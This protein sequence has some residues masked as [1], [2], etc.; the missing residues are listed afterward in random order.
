[1]TATLN[2]RRR[3]LSLGLVIL[4]LTAAAMLVGRWYV[5][6][7]QW[8]ESTDNAYIA[9]NLVP[10]STRLAGTVI[11]IGAEEN[12]YIDAGQVILRLENSDERNQVEILEQE[13]ALATRAVAAL[14]EQDRRRATEVDQREVTLQLANEEHQRRLKLAEVSMVSVEEL[15]A[16]RTRSEETRISRDIARSALTRSRLLSGHMPIE[17]HPSVKL[18]AAKLRAAH[19]DLGKT[20][21]V[22]PVSGLLAVRSVQLGQHVSPGEKL[23]SLVQLESVWVE[24]NFKET[25]LTHLYQNQAVTLTSDLYGDELVFTGV[26]SGIGSG[27]GALFSLLPPQNATGNWIKIVQRVPVRIE[28][29][30]EQLQKYPLPLGASLSVVV[31]TSER[32]GAKLNLNSRQQTIFAMPQLAGSDEDVDKAISRIISENIGAPKTKFNQR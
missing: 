10:L 1:M 29:P 18:A 4:V 30:A 32:T 14:R 7:G 12:Q 15:D 20:E 2:N 17:Q 27:T 13:L 19:L 16:A 8:R 28:L 31:N 26:V 23:M 22:A 25:Q 9:G 5:N 24:A 6:E 3:L 11:W 21:I